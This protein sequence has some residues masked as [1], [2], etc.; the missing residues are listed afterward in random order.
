ML[1]QRPHVLV[2]GA[3]AASLDAAI[4]FDAAPLPR[5]RLR[6]TKWL[7]SNCP[8]AAPRTPKLI[9]RTHNDYDYSVRASVD[10]SAGYPHGRAFS[11][12]CRQPTILR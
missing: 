6:L 9:P 2:H 5:R 10:L 7:F 4:A 11:A 1:S 8:A 12:R 3:D